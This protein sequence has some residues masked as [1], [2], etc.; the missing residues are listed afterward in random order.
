MRRDL[1]DGI[2]RAFVI[3]NAAVWIL[4]IALVVLDV[5]LILSGK[6]TPGDRVIDGG[7]VKTL[8]G[9]TA[10][11]VGVIMVAIASNLFSRTDSKRSPRRSD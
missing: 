6:E 2:L 8:V 3:G 10:V 1:A 7:V 4:V 9:A 11:Q 5:F